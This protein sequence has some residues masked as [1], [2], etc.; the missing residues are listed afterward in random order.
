MNTSVNDL[1][2]L[3]SAEGC[4]SWPT[5]NGIN[6]QLISMSPDD[7]PEDQIENVCDYLASVLKHESTLLCH[8]SGL[9]GML[10]GLWEEHA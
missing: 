8:R 1:Y 6:E 7:I 10:H 4:L 9:E 5:C 2:Q 3:K